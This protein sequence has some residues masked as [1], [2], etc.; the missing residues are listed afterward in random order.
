[1][2][3]VLDVRTPPRVKFQEKIKI[4][5][6]ENSHPGVA[7]PLDANSAVLEETTNK[8]ETNITDKSTTTWILLSGQTFST[9]PKPANNHNKKP[10]ENVSATPVAQTTTANVL[11]LFPAI[12][13]QNKN[14]IIKENESTE[15]KKSPTRIVQSL[16]N[17]DN[18]SNITLEAKDASIS[19]DNEPTK[20]TTS[21]KKKKNKNKRRKPSEKHANNT[22]LTN[23]INNLKEGT[24]GNQLYSYL[25]REIVPTLGVGLVGLVVTA[26]LAGY[27]LYHPFG[28]ISRVDTNIDRKDDKI[29]QYYYR[30]KYSGGMPEE[31]AIGEVIAGMSNN[32]FFKTSTSKTPHPNKG[33]KAIN[34][35]G[36]HQN[37]KGSVEK[38]PFTF[39]KVHQRVAGYYEDST[40]YQN[41]YFGTPTEKTVFGVENKMEELNQVKM[42]EHGPRNLR[43]K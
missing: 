42:S 19:L 1:M 6:H 35:A 13:K 22:D 27:F 32:L 18:A 2:Y 29:H 30:D 3:D 16:N 21:S 8:S 9:T 43:N 28:P 11:S 12:K 20:K 26:G 40:Q 17:T 23:A 7:I 4:K 39:E 33:Y 37:I 10:P 38:V 25:S 24:I 36:K 14:K 31:E 41:D 34:T 15:I 5:Q